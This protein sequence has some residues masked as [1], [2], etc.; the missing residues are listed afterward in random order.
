MSGKVLVVDYGIGNVFSVCNA[1]RRIGGDVELTGDLKAI[2]EA[3]RV[4]LPGVGAFARAMDALRAKGIVSALQDFIATG[5]PFM[6]VCIGMQV[7]MERSTEFGENEGLGFLRGEV[8]RIPG[9]GP[10]GSHLRVPH[11]GW[12]GLEP[13][14]QG[15]DGTPLA[16]IRPK[17]DFVYFVHSYHC[18]PSDPSRILATVDYGGVPVTAAI[19]Q[20]N[21]IGVQFHPER[22]GEVGQQILQAFLDQ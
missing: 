14:E 22:S 21:I 12:A 18:V 10:D 3:D 4:I 11:I 16:G 15:W 19:R 9:Q 1:I 20:E 8:V 2:R 17:E 6:G 7:L 13:K 5:R